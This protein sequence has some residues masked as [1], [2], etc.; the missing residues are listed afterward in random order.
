MGIIELKCEA[1]LCWGWG[2]QSISEESTLPW[3]SDDRQLLP[4]PSSL[5]RKAAAQ[6]QLCPRFFPQARLREPG[7]E[8][9][10]PLWINKDSV[11]PPVSAFKWV[12]DESGREETRTRLPFYVDRQCAKVRS[13]VHQHHPPPHHPPL[14]RSTQ[15]QT[16]RWHPHRTLCE[17]TTFPLKFH[18]LCVC[19]FVPFAAPGLHSDP[20]TRFHVTLES[21]TSEKSL[22]N[23]PLIHGRFVY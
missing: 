9:S 4:A 12:S 8:S 20:L 21:P 17:V 18:R 16:A 2:L 1:Q 23:H 19:V 6:S 22:F 15:T 13:V 5:L 3:S 7:T 11:H 10:Y 14:L